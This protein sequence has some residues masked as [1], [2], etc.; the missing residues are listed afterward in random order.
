MQIKTYRAPSM[1]AAIAAV[2]EGLGPDAVV[3][4]TRTIRGD[5]PLLGKSAIEITDVEMEDIIPVF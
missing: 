5:N 2:K 1:K 3:L 4:S